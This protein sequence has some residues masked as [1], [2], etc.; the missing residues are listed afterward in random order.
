MSNEIEVAEIKFV[1]IETWLDK[2]N[3][4][5]AVTVK[6]SDGNEQETRLKMGDILK[7]NV[8]PFMAFYKARR[9]LE[10]ASPEDIETEA[11]RFLG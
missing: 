7:I 5:V 8:P 9:W 1:S 2:A 3:P 4:A 6:F 11:R 10:D